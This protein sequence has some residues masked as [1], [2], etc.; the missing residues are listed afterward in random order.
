M[1][2]VKFTIKK[3]SNSEGKHS[4]VIQLIKDRKNTTIS[5]NKSIPYED[6]SFETQRVKSQNKQHKGLNSFI[7]KYHDLLDQQIDEFELRGAP[8]SIHDLSKIVKS[9]FSSKKMAPSYTAYQQSI[10]DDNSNTS[11]RS[12][13]NFYKDTLN[14]L[15]RCFG[16]EEIFFY[17]IT[18]N[19]LFKYEAFMRSGNISDATIGIRM[20]TLRSVI[21]KAI[22]SELIPESYYP[23]KK[24]KIK[25]A[26][27]ENSKEILTIE[28]LD[29]FKSFETDF[30][31]IQLAKDIFLFSYYSRGINFIDLMQLKQNNVSNQSITYKRSKTGV[32]VTFKLNI[33]SEEILNKYRNHAPN[34]TFLFSFLRNENPQ[35]NTI[36]NIKK[37]RL[38][39]INR[40]LKRIMIDLGIRKN[41]TYYCARHTFATHLK[42]NNIS[43]DIIREALGH[44]DINSTIS[45]LKS[46]PSNQLDKIIE[47]VI[48]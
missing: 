33:R 21:N 45:Y 44:K 39:E 32:I 19:F 28:E 29:L 36:D 34:A 22:K 24:Y 20:R 13:N 7:T 26:R 4:I 43:I 27:N 47:D 46:L 37:K 15:K 2:S 25:T 41:I 38:K 23:F 16:K 1:T 42:F 12:T 9:G 6:W 40:N 18:S 10:I 17:E 14:S 3:T 35:K 31:E 30:P 11:K 5:L 48:N 8:Y